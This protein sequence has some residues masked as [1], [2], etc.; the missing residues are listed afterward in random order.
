MKWIVT[1]NSNACCFYSY[2]S[3]KL[4]ALKSLTHPK[5]KLQNRELVTDRPGRY[6]LGES[7]RGAYEPQTEPE[8][9]ESEKFAQ[10][11][12]RELNNGRV[13]HQFDGLIIIMP[14]QMEGL[15]SKHLNKEVKEQI[16]VILHK[17]IMDFSRSELQDYIKRHI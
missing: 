10:E 13:H 17:N 11:I 6:K 2:D 3:K 15:L 1:A 9:V 5:G 16:H 12:A 4:D 7:T 14:A 8:K